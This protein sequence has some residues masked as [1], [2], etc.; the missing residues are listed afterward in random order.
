MNDQAHNLRALKLKSALAESPSRAPRPR[1]IA[2]T[3]GKGGVGV[4][5]LTINLA[6]ALARQG[7]RVL[8]ASATPRPNDLAILCG[9]HDLPDRADSTAPVLGPAGLLLLPPRHATTDSPSVRLRHVAQEIAR[10]GGCFD[11]AIVDGGNRLASDDPT[12]SEAMDMLLY[13]TT[14]DSVAVMDTYAAIKERIGNPD[15]SAQATV[16]TS[17]GPALPRLALVVNRC[18]E[19]DAARRA[20][21]RIDATCRRFLNTEVPRLGDVPDDRCLHAGQSASLPAVVQSPTS[22][23]A[24]AINSIATRLDMALAQHDRRKDARSYVGAQDVLTVP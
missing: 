5:T 7:N 2:V 21:E 22:G 13:V 9:L 20:H 4:S 3:G 12:I 1:T 16:E 23:A 15:V 11:L 24:K 17:D 18:V 6:A 10:L 14:D 19:A 8:V